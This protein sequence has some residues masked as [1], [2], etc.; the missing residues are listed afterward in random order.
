MKVYVAVQSFRES[1]EPECVGV[2]K[3]KGKAIS[4]LKKTLDYDEEFSAPDSDEPYFGS[5]EWIVLLKEENLE[6]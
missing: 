3:D 2:W 5:T 1:D 6:V 4:S